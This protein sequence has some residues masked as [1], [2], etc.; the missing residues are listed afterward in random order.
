[1][2]KK[3]IW[4]NFSGSLKLRQPEHGNRVTSVTDGD[5]R[6]DPLEIIRLIYK[7]MPILAV[8]VFA[9]MV[10][11][12]VIVFTMPNQY[13]STASIL[14]SGKSDNFSTLKELAGLSGSGGNTDENSSGLFP[15][16]LRSH[17][18]SDAILKKEYNFKFENKNFN[19]KLNDYFGTEVPSYL[20]KNLSDITAIEMDKKT[21]VIS[22]SVETKYPA[23]SQEILAAYLDELENFNMYKRK[24]SAGQNVKYLEREL[25][26]H[27]EE[28]RQAE[29]DLE[30]YQ[31][32]NRNWDMTTDPEI[33]KTIG[34]MKRDITVKSETYLFIRNQY[35]LSR[36]EEQKDVPIVR[37]L[38]HPSLP[39]IKSSPRRMTTIAMTGAASFFIFAL[40]LIIIDSIKSIQTTR[41]VS[42]APERNRIIEKIKEGVTQ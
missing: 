29:N 30:T 19:L 20:Y 22:M 25:A 9:V 37:I 18:V 2:K 11:T 8:A 16:I 21:G 5:L 42:T 28:L 32:A 31:M 1:M 35:E 39:Q 40:I 4:K 38:D 12:A 34:R 14:P 41:S 3:I 6:I 27:E 36:L 24:S 17:T 23:L 26:E 10:I 15:R 33:L 7:N 13:T